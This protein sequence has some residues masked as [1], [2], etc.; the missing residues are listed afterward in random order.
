MGRKKLGSVGF[1]GN[2]V[3][4]CLVFLPHLPPFFLYSRTGKAVRYIHRSGG[5]VVFFCFFHH[6]CVS[7]WK[8]VE[9]K[10]P[11]SF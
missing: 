7:F 1:I 3:V 8:A 4:V 11:T 9:V 2:K 6:N 5:G 10:G